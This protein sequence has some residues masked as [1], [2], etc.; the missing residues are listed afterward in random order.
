MF[1]NTLCYPNL[2]A[3]YT[4][5]L[6]K[7]IKISQNNLA[8][9]KNIMD[10]QE[11]FEKKFNAKINEQNTQISEILTLLK[12]LEPEFEQP[13]KNK[14]RSETKKAEFY[15]V[16]INWFIIQEKFAQTFLNHDLGS[17]LY[18]IYIRL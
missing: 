13:Q 12:D 17:F 15:Q 11:R 9:I 14:G 10:K 2:L 16:N 3:N 5:E 4:Q 1:I 7:L 6:V 18:I 8:A